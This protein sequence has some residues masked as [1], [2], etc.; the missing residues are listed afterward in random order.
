MSET[1]VTQELFQAVTGKNP[2]CFDG[3]PGGGSHPKDT[4]DGETQKKRPV[5]LVSRYNAIAFYNKLS[6]A[7]G[8]EPVY[9]G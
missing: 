9:T 5:E 3:S 7:N 4:P 6:L 2:S 1:E 8:K